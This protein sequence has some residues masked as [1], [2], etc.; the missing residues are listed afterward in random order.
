M[1][2]S[3][4]EAATAAATTWAVD[5]T[6]RMT[7]RACCGLC[8]G[9]YAM[10]VLSGPLDGLPHPVAH[11]AVEAVELTVREQAAS[12]GPVA[13]A[14]DPLAWVLLAMEELDAAAPRLAALRRRFVDPGV[15]AYL[16]RDPIV[17]VPARW[18]H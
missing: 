9:R 18:V 11:A 12:A 4:I 15:S 1:F 5:P 7:D 3:A 2:E 6:L 8:F 14:L 13:A 16:E 10:L 17:G